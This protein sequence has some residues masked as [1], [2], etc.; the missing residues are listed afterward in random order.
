MRSAIRSYWNRWFGDWGE[1]EAARL[2]RKRGLR[3]LV[4]GYRTSQGEIDLIARVGNGLAR[5]LRMPGV[6]MLL[7]L[8]RGPAR[9]AGLA[10]L[11]GFL[12]RGFA[13][14]AALGDAADFI[15]EIEADERAVSRRLFA[16]DADPF[17][18]G[19]D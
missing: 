13:A 11:Q 9:A 19:I 3:V 7:K 8:S 4:R 15:A 14:F 5:A 6:A 17:P 2:L 16:G 18:D 12:E 10:E 1:R